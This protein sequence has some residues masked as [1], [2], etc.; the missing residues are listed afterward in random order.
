MGIGV[1][2][3][4]SSKR[5]VYI[6]ICLFIGGGLILAIIN[7]QNIK[8]QLNAWK[9]LPE[10]EKLTELYFDNSSNLPTT[11]TPGQN[12]IF[13]FTFHNIEYVTVDYHY[14]VIEMN[15][16][17]G[18][19]Q[20]LTTG[21]DKLVQNQF[22]TVNVDTTLIDLGPRVEIVVSLPNVNESIDYWVNR[23]SS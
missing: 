2:Y 23:S 21:F 18:Q 5:I 9:L 11:Y 19:S 12:Q 13:S 10:P 17:T 8:N 20:T 4:I 1:L 15:Q 7:F 14:V 22:K 6:I 16:T 3:H